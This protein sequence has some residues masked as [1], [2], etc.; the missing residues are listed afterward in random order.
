MAHGLL[1]DRFGD[2]ALRL[3]RLF[4]E[5]LA[6]V[7]LSDG[8]KVRPGDLKALC[9]ASIRDTAEAAHRSQNLCLLVGKS[10]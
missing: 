4:E 8:R 6:V 3:R 2:T 10:G 5:L 1:S 7:G 9:C